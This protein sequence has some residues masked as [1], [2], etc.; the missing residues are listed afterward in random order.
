MSAQSWRRVVVSVFV[1]SLLSGRTLDAKVFKLYYLGGQS[2]MDGYGYTRELPDDLQG[3][4][5]GV[6]IF[7]GNTAADG[8]EE[9]GRGIWA[10]LRP[11]HGVDFASDGRTNAYSERCGVE[12][13]FARRLRELEPEAN[14]AIIKYSRGGTSIDISAADRFGCWDP[15]YSEGNGVNQYDHFLAT[16]R[17]A[18]AVR[19][20]DGDGQPDT[21]VPA[22]IVWMQGESDANAE[23]VA[24]QYQANLKR[25]MDLIRAAFR[26]DDLPVV[27]G[28]ISDSGQD[29]DGR[30]WDYGTAVREAQATFVENDESAAL[31]TTTDGYR[32]SDKWH[33]DT[34]GYIDLGRQFAQALADLHCKAK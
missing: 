29:P 5:R 20:I 26:R 4:V 22:G 28:R 31:V 34:A 7:H 25:L 13:T 19:D 32:Y 16:V 24:Q 23:P 18:L 15:D 21:L 6:M 1:A 2:N 11:G 12:I 10:E 9:D 8:V 14:I 30:V 33:Y 3:P 17:N 27:I